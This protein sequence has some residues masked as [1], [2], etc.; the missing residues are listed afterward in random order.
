MIFKKLLAALWAFNKF[1]TLFQFSI[2]YH[3]Q[4]HQLTIKIKVLSH[5]KYTHTF[6]PSLTFM[7]ASSLRSQRP[8]FCELPF[9]VSYFHRLPAFPGRRSFAFQ[10]GE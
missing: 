3:H 8:L 2:F 9:H 1:L 7:I 4:R 10:V 5:V 6:I